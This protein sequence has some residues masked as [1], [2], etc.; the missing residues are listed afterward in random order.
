MT[1][2]L[3][4]TTLPLAQDPDLFLIDPD[5]LENPFHR[6]KTC[7][8]VTYCEQALF[9]LPWSSLHE[10]PEQSSAALDVERGASW[11]VR[12]R[13]GRLP[14]TVERTVFRALEW[15]A[16]DG[17]I[18]LGHPFENPLSLHLRELCERLC[19]RVT[20]PRF[21]IIE[22]AMQTLCRLEIEQRHGR[23][24]PQRFGVLQSAVARRTRRVAA[25][26][27]C[28]EVEVSFDPRFVESINAGRIVPV[29]W[30]LWIPQRLMEVVE[31]EWSNHED[32]MSA[33]FDADLLCRRIPIEATR[34]RERLLA[35]AHAE[36]VRTG[37]LRHVETLPS[38]RYRYHPGSTFLATRIR[39]KRR[40]DQVLQT[41]RRSGTPLG[42]AQSRTLQPVLP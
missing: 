37:Y 35:R 5:D 20:Q 23:G 10:R 9:R 25:G 33:T 8:V 27:T 30:G 41:A 36:L 32:L 7:S 2:A 26:T 31:S 39:L 12:S 3:A 29:N 42:A 22:E 14:G 6:L 15:M 13:G 1:P 38:G 19:W 40:T 11:T 28:P 4:A 17:S 16:I 21:R 24:V 18:A 34:N